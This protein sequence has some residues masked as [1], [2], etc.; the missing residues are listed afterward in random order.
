MVAENFLV[1]NDGALDGFPD[2]AL[3]FEVVGQNFALQKPVVR[4]DHAACSFP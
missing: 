4:E 1:L 3:A 2:H